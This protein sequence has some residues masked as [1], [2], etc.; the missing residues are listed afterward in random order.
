MDRGRT[1]SH[2]HWLQHKI[3]FSVH[4]ASLA[5]LFSFSVLGPADALSLGQGPDYSLL[6]SF[7]L[8]DFRCHPES[9]ILTPLALRLTGTSLTDAATIPSLMASA[10]V[11]QRA[12]GSSPRC[13]KMQQLA[14]EC[15][16]LG[17]HS[18]FSVAEPVF[19]NYICGGLIN[20]QNK[21]SFCISAYLHE[22]NCASGLNSSS[23]WVTLACLGPTRNWGAQASPRSH[24]TSVPQDRRH[25]D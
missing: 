7:L 15:R 2:T 16:P 14:S 11:S 8:W 3:L 18:T 6:C 25:T 19:A 9:L 10:R 20:L 4:T 12:M 23:I 17:S 21:R 24:S 5:W 1:G 13:R 22:T